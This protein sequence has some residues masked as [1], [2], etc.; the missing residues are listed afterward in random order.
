MLSR[1]FRRYFSTLYTGTIT[2]TFIP[3]VYFL[4]IQN[5]LVQKLANEFKKE[6]GSI[7][8]A[9]LLGL[10]KIPQEP[11]PEPRTEFYYKKRPSKELVGLACDIMENYLNK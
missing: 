7:I 4:Q 1:H 10:K 6:T 11:T 9:E 3:I 5:Y 8:C 2:D